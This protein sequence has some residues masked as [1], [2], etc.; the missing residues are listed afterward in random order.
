LDDVSFHKGIKSGE[1]HAGIQR[2]EAVFLRKKSKWKLTKMRIKP[3]VRT[4]NTKLKIWNECGIE[5]SKKRIEDNSIDLC[6]TDPPYGINVG[7]DDNKYCR[8][9]ERVLDGYVDIP[10]EEYEKFCNDF[11]KQTYRVLRAGGSAYVC[12]GW[13]NLEYILSGGRNAGLIQ[14]SHIVWKY[15]FGLNATNKWINSTTH[16]IYFVKPPLGN[17]TFNTISDDGMEISYHDKEDL[18][19]IPREPHNPDAIRNSN[20]LPHALVEKMISYSSNKGDKVLDFFMGGFTTA[21][22]SLKL[23]REPIG[24]EKNKNSFNYFMNELD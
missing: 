21:K 19:S 14:R 4:K 8:S 17:L 15:D 24:F 16:I 12:S 5:G 23:Q 10:P 20:Q 18:W 3:F 22:C 1:I 11:L 13:Q 6:L 9:S 2:R 7:N